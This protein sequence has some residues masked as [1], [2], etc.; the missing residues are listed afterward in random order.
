M[1]LWEQGIR[2]WLQKGLQVEIRIRLVYSDASNVP[3]AIQY[4]YRVVAYRA[5]WQTKTFVN[6]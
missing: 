3:A 4:S 5:P 1:R 6:R 2:A